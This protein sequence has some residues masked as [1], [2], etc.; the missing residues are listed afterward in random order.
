MKKSI[1][2]LILT[3]FIGAWTAEAQTWDVG[4]A[5]N[6]GGVASV[7]ATLSG[8]TLTISG[9]GAMMDAG[10]MIPVDHPWHSIRTFITTVV[11]EDGV[12]SIGDFAF[13][14]CT[15]LTSVTIPNSVTIIGEHAFIGCTGLTSV[16]IPNSVILIGDFAFY[17]CIGLTSVTIH[18]SVSETFIGGWAFYGCIGLTS[19]TIPNSVTVIGDY[20]FSR[21]TGLTSIN[22]DPNN[23]YYS[24]EDGVLFNKNKTTLVQYPA[25]KQGTSYTIPNSVTTI[26]EVAFSGCTGLTSV[27]IP[28]SVRIIRQSAFGGCTG[29]TSVTIPNS[30][31]TIERGVF[32]G[33][34]GLTSVTIPNSVTSIGHSPFSR[35]TG[36]TSINVD[37][38]NAYYSSEDG[39]L[40]NKNKTTLVQYPAGKQGAYTIPNSVTSIGQSAFIGCTGLTS[41]TIPNSVTSIG[42]SAFIGCT[43][44]TSVT[45]PNSVT[46]IGQSVFTDCTNLTSIISL[47]PIPLTIMTNTFSNTP[48]IKCLYVPQNS[49]NSYS[50]ASGWGSGSNMFNCIRD[51][52]YL[53]S[54]SVSSGTL[55]P[56]FTPNTT[57]YS[58]TVPNS[59]SSLTITAV[60]IYT[61]AAVTGTGI[62]TLNAGSNTFDIVVTEPGSSSVNRIY[63]ITVVRHITV[64]FDSQGGSTV[65]PQFVTPNDKVTKP[66]DP[67]RPNHT[68]DGWYRETAYTNQWD[69]D[70][71]VGTENITLYA[72]WTLNTY[73]VTFAD[74]LGNEIVVR[75][76]EH[77]TDATPPDNPTRETHNFTTWSGDYIN[78]TGDRTITAQWEIKTY[79]ITFVDGL[80]NEI[81]VRTVNHGASATPPSNPTRETHNFTNWS[82]DYTNVTSNRTI[83][84]LWEIK[85]YTV[86]FADGIGNE[87]AVRT[88]NHGADATPPDNPSRDT[89]NFTNWSGDYTNVTSNRTIT[90]LWEIKTY[91]VTWNTNGGT[92]VS[93]QTSI[94]HGNSIT[95]PTD[96]TKAGYTLGGWFIDED[97]ETAVT[98]PLENV[99]TAQTFYA[100]W[101][102]V[103]VANISISFPTTIGIGQQLELSG[104]V[105]P[106]NAKNQTIT[107]SIFTA[108]P[109]GAVVMDNGTLFTVT[110]GTAF[111]RATVINGRNNGT[112]DYTQN[113][114]ITISAHTSIASNDRA[115]PPLNT[116]SEPTL[117]A[118]VN[119]SFT[120]GPN[121]V[122]KQSGTVNF[123]WQGKQIQSSTLTIFDASGNIINR[124]RITDNLQDSQIWQ[125]RQVGSWNLTDRKGRLVSE[126]TY[127][128]RGMVITADGKRER[129]SVMVG[130][131]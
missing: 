43:G 64:T 99:T 120:A 108:S 123:F 68:F 116:E 40:F 45:I 16:I 128:V 107:W 42:Q 101:I 26:G 122:N 54:L 35:C 65:S 85:T 23:A 50:S 58:L 19:V 91:A 22:V 94:N 90:A 31:T 114:F 131:Q 49:I 87:I 125:R 86:T 67:A 10:W 61:E 130:V 126:G 3:L 69:F 111:I 117:L 1:I 15:G 53:S 80:G 103:P 74:G 55:S 89:H 36:L 21:C 70:T 6:T 48:A 46:S 76:V 32:S 72:K 24:Y 110:E 119:G 81:A 11:I 75:T 78:V 52:A 82:G 79:Y 93:T 106:Q 38:N 51:L 41:V 100:K 118:S 95:A 84:A 17:G 88:V 115:I 60:P 47:N 104:T 18:N 96:I 127:L 98:F 56:A 27:T 112:A 2:L 92:P 73:T 28:N 59:E 97:F 129:V 20:A 9:A 77:G 7:T 102:F 124:V 57:S 44:L 121:P 34:T 83:T 33:C 30:V 25:G 12:T 105:E 37:P 14:S 39:V 66:A 29:L 5:S 71:D 62:K 13:N 113:F 63:T 109:T 8:G 4:A